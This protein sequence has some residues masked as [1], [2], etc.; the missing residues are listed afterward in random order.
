MK[1][2]EESGR[3][4]GRDRLIDGLTGR[5]TEV[6]LGYQRVLAEDPRN[7]EA[8]VGMSVLAKMEQLTMCQ[9]EPR[10]D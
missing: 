7:A 10:V 8:L 4:G 6:A 5:L 9:A 2:A 1:M 3:R